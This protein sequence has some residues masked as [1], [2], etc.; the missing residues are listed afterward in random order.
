M[1]YLFMSSEK[2]TEGEALISATERDVFYQ[3]ILNALPYS[4]MLTDLDKRVIFANKAYLETWGK[5]VHDLIGQPC[6]AIK[7]D[8]CNTPQCCIDRF[9]INPEDSTHSYIQ[10]G[11]HFQSSIANLIDHNGQKVGYISF[12]IDKTEIRQKEKMLRV[13]DERGRLTKPFYDCGI[14]EYDTYDK[15]LIRDPASNDD[16]DI[17]DI[18]YNVPESLI[19]EGLFHP[20]SVEDVRNIFRML[21]EGEPYIESEIAIVRR[22]SKEMVWCRLAFTNVFDDDGR[23]IKAVGTSQ[24]ITKNKE[25]A[26][27]AEMERQNLRDQVH[28]D[29]LTGL[30]NREHMIE[31]LEEYLSNRP[32][33]SGGALLMADID[34]FR[35]IIE[36][37]GHQ[38]ADEFLQKVAGLMRD[39]FRESDWLCRTSADEFLIFIQGGDEAGA[40][41][42]AQHLCRLIGHLGKDYMQG[43]IDV[44]ASVGI[45]VLD[46]NKIDYGEIQRY[47]DKAL[48]AAK[49]QDG[50]NSCVVYTRILDT[51]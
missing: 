46:E 51:I 44:S 30:Y 2:K 18:N 38:T 39:H 12:V 16:F 32:S 23:L 26:L 37:L 49:S 42:K 10:D 9:R 5:E 48:F 6:N 22:V 15:S 43:G 50:K 35:A 3:N 29:Q 14:W 45:A 41:E 19:N 8:I 4:M 13:S 47:A 33:D 7:S 11:R 21:D 20:R 28:R 40:Y 36:T 1:E 25:A 27:A 24:D 34:D 17:P 31:K